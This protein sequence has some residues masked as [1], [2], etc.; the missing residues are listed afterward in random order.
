MMER[1]RFSLLRE[2]RSFFPRE[3]YGSE[4][5]R[6][7]LETRNRTPEELIELRKEFGKGNSGQGAFITIAFRPQCERSY[8]SLV[9]RYGTPLMCKREASM[10]L[11]IDVSGGKED[12]IPICSED[13]SKNVGDVYD[14]SMEE[15][16][17]YGV[18]SKNGW[19]RV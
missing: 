18:P 17:K 1:T 9:D 10:T 13:C 11:D 7:I 2:V 4:Q 15:Q 3:K 16:G 19:G 6:E 8:A 5:L 14:K 12:H